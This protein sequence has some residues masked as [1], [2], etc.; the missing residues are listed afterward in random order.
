MIDPRFLK[1]V[2]RV[3]IASLVAYLAIGYIVFVATL[4][5]WEVGLLPPARPVSS[6]ASRDTGVYG[7]IT[8]QVR[9]VFGDPVPYA[10]VHIGGRTIQADQNGN[11]ILEGLA[12]DRYVMEIFAGGYERYKWEITVGEGNNTPIIKYDSGLWPE[13]F[14]ADFHVFYASNDRLFGLVGFANGSHE[15]IYVSSATIIDPNG[16]AIIDVLRQHDGFNYY[17]YLSNKVEVVETPEPA[18]RIPSKAWV[19]GE[20]PPITGPFPPGTYHLEI[21]YGNQE[22]HEKQQYQRIQYSDQGDNNWNP[23]LP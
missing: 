17:N 1:R 19:N 5:R 21:L 10:V 3:G 12:P 2:L 18:L 7:T 15:T 4:V 23:H 8:S 16:N 20:I 9:N 13:K 14:L 6:I 22:E 11:F